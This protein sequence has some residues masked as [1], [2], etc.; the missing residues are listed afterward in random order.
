M[1]APFPIQPEL[2]AI[3]IA[4]RNQSLIADEVLPRVPVGKQDF[5]YLKHAMAEGFTLPD[6]KVGRR[7]KPNDV[8]FSA[9]EITA[10]T[11]DFGLDDPVPRGTSRMLLPTTTRWVVPLKGSWI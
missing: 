10:S 7:S 9:T 1:P 4:Y 6:T 11:E 3:A 8:E 5:K 2:T